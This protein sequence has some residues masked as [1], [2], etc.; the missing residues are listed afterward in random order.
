MVAEREE[1]PELTVLG[2]RVRFRVAESMRE[3]LKTYPL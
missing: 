1:P 2:V 3:K